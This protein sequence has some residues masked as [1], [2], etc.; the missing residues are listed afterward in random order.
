MKWISC[1]LALLSVA[2]FS[3][4]AMFPAVAQPDDFC[5][6]SKVTLPTKQ[7]VESATIFRAGRVYDFLAEPAEITIYDP[8]N[9]RFVVL[10]PERKVKVEIMTDEIDAFALKVKA[11]AISR[12]VPLLSFLANPVFAES[13]DEATGEL[14]LTS[15]WLDYRV[16][17]AAPKYADMA[18]Q[19][20]EF[21]NWQTKLNTLMN[22]GSFPP[23]PRLALNTSLEKRE[24]IP[25]E[26][27]LTKYAHHPSRK[28]ISLRADHRLQSRLLESDQKRLDEADR[29]LVTFAP[30]G[31]GEYRQKPADEAKE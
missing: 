7:T 10:D 27:E 26:V 4:V 2:A 30:V 17:T 24:R 16:K 6:Q 22:P 29:Y 25:V 3:A 23:F 20:V 19:Y 18:R 12:N 31:L 9:R 8:P 13:Y 11:Q 28:P 1:C 15:E 14:A 21:T 5:I